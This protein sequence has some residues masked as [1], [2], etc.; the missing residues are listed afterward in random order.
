MN[1]II[2]THGS[3]LNNASF[4]NSNKMYFFLKIQLFIFVSISIILFLYYI[5]FRYGLMQ[6]EQISDELIDNFGITKIYG[7]NS[8]YNS[9]LLTNENYFYKNSSFSVIGIIE[10]KK[11]DICYPILS[12]IDKD[13]L[14][15]APCYF[16]GPHPNMPRESLYCRA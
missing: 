15:I 12:N 6:K 3:N 10:I 2:C 1:Q 11:I 16:Y 4:S 13:L 9:K 8:D 14:K 5:F 7:N